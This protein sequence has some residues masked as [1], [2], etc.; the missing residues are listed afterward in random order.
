MK[1]LLTLT[2]ALLLLS[3]CSEPKTAGQ[4]TEEIRTF[5]DPQIEAYKKAQKVQGVV[6]I[7]AA[8]HEEDMRNSEAE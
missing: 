1:T 5:A 8:Q 4:R 3:A 6:D 7:Q 2:T